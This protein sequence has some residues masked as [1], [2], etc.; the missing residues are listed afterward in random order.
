MQAEGSGEAEPATSPL[1]VGNWRLVWTRQGQSANPL[2]KA[3]A[4]QV[5][6]GSGGGVGW[7]ALAGSRCLPE[8]AGT[9][10]PCLPHFCLSP[11]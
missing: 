10:S 7:T 6:A 11:D 8:R 2:Q 9:R 3:L 4:N 5:G 1:A